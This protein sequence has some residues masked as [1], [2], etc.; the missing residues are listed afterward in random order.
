MPRS[1]VALAALALLAAAPVALFAQGA[2]PILLA[3][4]DDAF[5]KAM[6]LLKRPNPTVKEVD[7]AGNMLMKAGPDAFERAMKL[8]DR[9]KVGF[10][11][12][13]VTEAKKSMMKGGPDS[14]KQAMELLRRTYG[15]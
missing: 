12:A 14:S 6:Q 8:L 4:K 15:Y 10:S 2:Q 3:Q 13:E 11:E 9:P 1:P 5:D 7:E